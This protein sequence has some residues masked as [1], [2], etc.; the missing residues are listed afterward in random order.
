MT[1]IE[2]KTFVKKLF[3]V[4]WK[5]GDASKFSDFYHDDVVGHYQDESFGFT[6]I[7]ARLQALHRLSEGRNFIFKDIIAIDELITFYMT[8]AWLIKD[9]T[10]MSI[11]DV[12]GVYRMKA[13]KISEVWLMT[14]KAIGSYQTTTSKMSGYLD[15]HAQTPKNKDA[16][17]HALDALLKLDTSYQVNLKP[18]EYDCLYYYLSGYTAKEIGRKLNLSHRTIEDYIVILKQKF[19]CHTRGQLRQLL[20][21]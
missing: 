13:G 17:K 18:L 5:Q 6:E 1:N 15:S 9:T 12:V 7:K 4:I 20:L 2:A 14:E 11:S 16:F 10:K 21:N 8:Q 3:E 19:H